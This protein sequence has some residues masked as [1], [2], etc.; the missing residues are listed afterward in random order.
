[1][2]Y[3]FL[4]NNELILVDY[5]PGSSG[6]LLLR[7]WSELDSVLSYDVEGV[8]SKTSIE[9]HPSTREIEYEILIPKR[10][11]NWFLDR[12]HPT[13]MPDHAAYYEFLGTT[14]VA[15]SEKWK[16][17]Q[18]GRKF[19]DGESYSLAGQRRLYGIHTWYH[20]VPFDEMRD[21][22]LGVRRI[23]IV[24]TTERGRRYQFRRC[25]LCYPGDH[26]WWQNSIDTFNAKRFETTIDLCTMLVDRDT[27][28][29]VGALRTMIGN[30]FREEKVARA[31]EILE[32]Y[33]R[34]IVD[35]L[36]VEDA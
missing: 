28:A 22:G 21:A 3:P 31:S 36:S 19:Y 6:Q 2:D 27:T 26:G 29:I 16:R 23:S 24:P 20:E 11:T 15:L 4:R 10:M 33:Y 12:C 1:M 8:I 30:G 18:K 34:E 9:P 35:P 13:S 5:L 25:T 17:G 7:L 32:I 14:L